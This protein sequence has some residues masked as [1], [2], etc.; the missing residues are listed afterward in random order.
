[1]ALPGLIGAIIGTLKTALKRAFFKVGEESAKD[2]LKGIGKS[3]LTDSQAVLLNRLKSAPSNALFDYTASAMGIQPSEL[4]KVIKTFKQTPRMA[5]IAKGDKFKKAVGRAIEK[6]LKSRINAEKNRLF[7]DLGIDKG[8]KVADLIRK[9]NVFATKEII[10]DESDRR[11]FRSS[12]ILTTLKNIEI[13]LQ[14]KINGIEGPKDNTNASNSFDLDVQKYFD[15]TQNYNDSTL[16]N[17]DAIL[18]GMD[19]D[20]EQYLN[21][22]RDDL[23][24]VKTGKNQWARYTRKSIIAY[25]NSIKEDVRLALSIRG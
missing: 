18:E 15:R 4:R 8:F 13:A 1:M 24:L 25:I 2:A 12:D 20:L 11:Q 5:E 10:P 22:S 6:E 3:I 7:S 21:G 23:I 9:A 19:T 16:A 14:Y 17:L